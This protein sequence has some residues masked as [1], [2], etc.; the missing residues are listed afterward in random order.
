M[1]NTE[2]WLVKSSQVEGEQ[3]V[4]SPSRRRVSLSCLT[5]LRCGGK[6]YDVIEHVLH[7]K[8][9]SLRM[10]GQSMQ[11]FDSMHVSSIISSP[12]AFGII[13]N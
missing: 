9:N 11:N 4:V 10:K 2:I 12:S 6:G 3:I 7:V 1:T 8:S 5:A 13:N